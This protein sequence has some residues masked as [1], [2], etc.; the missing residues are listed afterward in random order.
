MGNNSFDSSDSARSAGPLKYAQSL[1]LDGPHELE[2]GGS[3]GHVDVVYETY[4]KLSEAKD[5]AILIC[6]ALSGDS[7]VCQHDESDEPGWWDIM[8]G[9]GKSIDT[10][11]YF[12]ICPNVL[13]GCSGTTGPNSINPATGKQFGPDFPHITIGDMVEVQRK[14]IDSLGIDKL[15]AVIG[16][17]MGGHQAL[18]WGV[19]YSDRSLGVVPIATSPRLTTQS[20]AFDVVGRNAIIRDPHFHGGHYYDKEKGPSVG[21]A[22]ARMIGHITYLSAESMQDKFEDD[23]DRPRDVPTGFENLFSVGSYLGYKGSEFV[24]R[25]DANSY[26]TLSMAMDTLDLGR[27][28][29]DLAAAFGESHARWLVMSISSDWLFSPAQSADIVRALLSNNTPV[30]YCNVASNC[31]HDAFLLENDLSCY[32]G[33]TRAFLANLDGGG[34]APTPHSSEDDATG[35]RPTSIFQASRLDYDRIM[36]LIPTN[37]SVLDLG[38]GN[39]SLM[40][41]LK[42]R[43]QRRI[44]GVELDER[45]ILSCVRRGLDVVQA[46]LNDGLSDFANK[47]FDIVVLSQTLQTVRDVK[48]VVRDMIHVGNK[49]IVSFPNFAYHKLR[50]MLAEDGKAPEAAGVL[51]FKWYDTP[52]IRFVSIA[53]FE[54]FCEERGIKVDRRI[55]LDTET[56]TEVTDDPNLNADLAI[57]VLGQ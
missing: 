56:R 54:E 7:H 2:I 46:D 29:A 26:I 55:C 35:E 41:R 57:F 40:M 51:R 39:G 14:L 27:G 4:G 19:R 6:H 16:G 48:R 47:Q 20:L 45:A 12:V 44:M 23:R 24:D 15:L 18:C 22:L 17:S 38:C 42:K 30:S 25:F 33:L 31:G 43:G 1:R 10:D 49:C 8:V 37:A 53:D 9:P 28:K 5:N 34:V 13:G 52:N 32:G 21:L 3:L 11:K 50:K 36:E